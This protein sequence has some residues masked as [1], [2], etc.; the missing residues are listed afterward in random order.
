MFISSLSCGVKRLPRTSRQFFRSCKIICGQ[1]GK[2]TKKIKESEIERGM[3]DKYV[4]QASYKVLL[5]SCFLLSYITDDMVRVA[6]LTNTVPPNPF[7]NKLI[8][9]L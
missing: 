1:L 7:N 5:L 2:A 4:T 9:N 3:H 8:N 6:T